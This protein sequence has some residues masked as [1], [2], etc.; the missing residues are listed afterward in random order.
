MIDQQKLAAFKPSYVWPN[1][2][3]H[4]RLYYQSTK[5]RV[6]LIENIVHNW[7]WLLQN[8][9]KIRATDF[10]FVQLGWYFGDW[11]AEECH[12]ALEALGIPKSHFRIMYPDFATKSLFEFYGFEGSIV[13][14]NA[15]LDESKFRIIH[16]PK[17]YDAVYVARLSPFKR[18]HLAA[19]IENLALVAGNAWGSEIKEL[20]PYSYLNEQP[21]DADGVM[22]KLAESKVGILL[23]EFEGACYSS[24]EYLL[25]GLPVVSTWSHGG[26]S[27]WYNDYNSVICN[28]DPDSVAKAVRDLASTGRNPEK[29]RS[30]HIELARQLRKNFVTL[31]QDV[32]N[33]S[34]D[35]QVDALE[36]FNLNFKHKLLTSE[37]PDFK[38]I[39]G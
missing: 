18:H 13:N 11:L 37:T 36:Y 5:C 15:F 27:I 24:S 33:M 21:L 34:G 7:N 30:M 12:R 6:F 17:I 16:S 10:F 26:R 23:S 2:A 1:P 28:A 31:H 9:E 38:S 25:C 3:F 22:Q 14:H 35:N 20:P 39:F 32:L 29:I 19:K 4:F 8:A